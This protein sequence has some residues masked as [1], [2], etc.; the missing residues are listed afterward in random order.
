MRDARGKIS[1]LARK[2][3]M[4]AQQLV[5]RFGF[6]NCSTTVQRQYEN[7]NNNKFEEYAVHHLIEPNDPPTLPPHF[8]YR[9]CYWEEKGDEYTALQIA[10][11]YEKPFIAPRWEVVGNNTYGVS[12]GMDALPDVIQLQHMTRKRAQGLDKQAVSYTHLTLPTIYSV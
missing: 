6:E 2:F 9:E 1:F 12:P 8:T 5:S 10:G 4:T 7:A 3:R 11:Y